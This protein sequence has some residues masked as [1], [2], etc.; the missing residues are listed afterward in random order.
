MVVFPVSKFIFTP[1]SPA[2][3]LSA[4]HF[5][6]PTHAF[7]FSNIAAVSPHFAFN[8]RVFIPVVMIFCAVSLSIPEAEASASA[9]ISRTFPIASIPYCVPGA[10]AA[11]WSPAAIGALRTLNAAVL[12]PAHILEM[13]FP[14]LVGSWT[15]CGVH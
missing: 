10:S 15:S 1:V 2:A 6:A 13:S 4:A 5:K 11:V 12:A 9:H 7:A 3:A 8:P 14:I